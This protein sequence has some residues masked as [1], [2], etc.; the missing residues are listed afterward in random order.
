MQKNKVNIVFHTI[1]NNR[2]EISNRYDYVFEDAI[3]LVNKIRK[4]V[5]E[6][7]MKLNVFLD[8]GDQSQFLFAKVLSKE[9]GLNVH[10]ALIANCVNKCGYLSDK[11]IKILEEL[12]VAFC[13][14]G[15]S[16]AAL[17]RYE[18]NMVI[19]TPDGGEYKDFPRG[20]D[21]LLCKES[22][23]FQIKESFIKLK[24]LNIKIESFV[25]PYGIYNEIIKRV[26]QASCLYNRAYTCDN[27]IEGERSDL[28]ATPRFMIYNDVSTKELILSIKSF[29]K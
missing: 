7:G 9:I 3:N 19:I 24:N 20:H 23:K 1:V 29:L 2:Q 8:D 22:V 26:V 13:S 11:E 4:I 10:I 25:Y 17:G 14:H 6:K 16:H 21:N 12:G 15:F 27:G 5:E 18:N 28:F